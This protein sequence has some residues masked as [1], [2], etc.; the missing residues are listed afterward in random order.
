MIIAAIATT[1]RFFKLTPDVAKMDQDNHA[2][3]KNKRVT[4][5]YFIA[6]IKMR[7]Y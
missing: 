2:Q 7:I 1:S 5:I 6:L 4:P 3:T